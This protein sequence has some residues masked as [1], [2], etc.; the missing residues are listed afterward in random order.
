MTFFDEPATDFPYVVVSWNYQTGVPEDAADIMIRCSLPVS[1]TVEF[2]MKPGTTEI[3]IHRYYSLWAAHK[4]KDVAP[5]FF[6]NRSKNEPGNKQ[7]GR[8]L[9]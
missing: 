5:W 8:K 9:S 4:T 3:V 7:P 6:W 2:L 1:T